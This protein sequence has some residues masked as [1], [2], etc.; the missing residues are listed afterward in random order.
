MSILRSTFD[1]TT[2]EARAARESMLAALEEIRQEVDKAV[3]GGGE[4]YMARH[5]ARGKLLARE[6]IE[7]LLDRLRKT[8]GNVEFLMQ[9]QQTS[10]IRLDDE[11]DD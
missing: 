3:A 11:D 9:V 6:R 5:K 1:P 8:K 2:E 4:K 10:S 7:L